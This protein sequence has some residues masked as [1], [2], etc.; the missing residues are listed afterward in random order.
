[1]LCGLTKWVKKDQNSPGEGGL[2]EII[3]AHTVKF[4]K[5][6]ERMIQV[7]QVEEAEQKQKLI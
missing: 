5:K 6:R 1:M 7:S 3:L 4:E 2:N